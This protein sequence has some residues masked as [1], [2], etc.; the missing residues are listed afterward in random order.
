MYSIRSHYGKPAACN[1]ESVTVAISVSE[2]YL[3][4]GCP[5]SGESPRRA[6]GTQLPRPIVEILLLRKVGPNKYSPCIMGVGGKVFTLSPAITMGLLPVTREALQE[7]AV[8][9]DP[10]V[11]LSKA[12]RVGLFTP[13]DTG[14]QV[15][16]WFEDLEKAPVARS[17]KITPLDTVSHELWSD[18]IDP[19]FYGSL[20]RLAVAARLGNKDALSSLALLTQLDPDITAG[21]AALPKL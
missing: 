19:I 16:D 7:I 4:I 17:E 15:A 21:V 9:P 14:P 2:F 12:M 6:P 20:I 18:G 3:E 1:G 13:R 5:S 11:V 10:Y 8:E